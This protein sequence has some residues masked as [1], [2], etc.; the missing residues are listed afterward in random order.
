M[1]RI[2]THIPGFDELIGGGFPQNATILLNG[3]PGTGKTIFSLQY[4][5]NSV[6]KDKKNVIYFTFEEKKRALFEQ[7]AQFGWDLEK[8]EKQGKFRIISIGSEDISKNTMNDVI[9]IIENTKATRIVVDSLS[10]LS[11]LVPENTINGR[12]SDSQI[13]KFLYS[14]ITSIKSH[15]RVT[16]LF[17]SQKDEELVSNLASYICDGVINIEYES[18]GGDYSR[19]LTVRKMRQVKNNEDLHPMEISKEG[20]VIHNLE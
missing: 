11:F 15:S 13:K 17:I 18:L 3:G 2:K 7:A 1:T 8:L 4:L 14:F 5:Y 10:T 16:T 6:T 12:I 9:E 19:N 20:V